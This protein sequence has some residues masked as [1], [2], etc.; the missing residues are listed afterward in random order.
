MQEG[1]PGHVGDGVLQRDAPVGDHRD[2]A[3]GGRC[4]GAEHLADGHA[5]VDAAGV[6][7]SP[8]LGDEQ[9][10]DEEVLHVRGVDAVRVVPLVDGKEHG[11]EGDDD[12][13]RHV[14]GVEPHR[15]VRVLRLVLVLAVLELQVQE[16]AVEDEPQNVIESLGPGVGDRHAE[17]TVGGEQRRAEHAEDE[18][19]GEVQAE[20]EQRHAAGLVFEPA[21]DE[22]N[23]RDG[24]E[25]AGRQGQKVIQRDTGG[26]GDGLKA[27]FSQFRVRIAV[28]R[29]QCI[30]ELRQC[31]EQV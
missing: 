26:N 30:A 13:E 15:S 5:H 1:Q 16:D 9:Q 8:E 6:P 4:N 19:P 2:A 21:I 3:Q 18:L 20:D 24:P 28:H 23:V 14:D 31:G 7:V 22:Q 17:V 29:G 12:L 11:R 25:D 10:G 27:H